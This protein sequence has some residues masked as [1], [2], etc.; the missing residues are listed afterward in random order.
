LNLQINLPLVEYGFFRER[1]RYQ[2]LV[3]DRTLRTFA[4]A[5]APFALKKPLTQRTLRISQR[6][7]E[8]ESYLNRSKQVTTDLPHYP[9]VVVDQVR[10]QALACFLIGSLKAEL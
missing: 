5:L 2:P 7:A 8:V 9:C 10:V 6:Y 3:I 4:T 1:K